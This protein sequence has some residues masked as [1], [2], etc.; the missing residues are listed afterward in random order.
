[1]HLPTSVKHD[2]LRPQRSSQYLPT[3]VLPHQPAGRYCW[4]HV[5]AIAPR[6]RLQQL[7]CSLP[8]LLSGEELPDPGVPFDWRVVVEVK[9]DCTGVKVQFP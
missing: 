9:M 3:L 8:G 4:D 5:S 7:G 1:M 2:A 6:A